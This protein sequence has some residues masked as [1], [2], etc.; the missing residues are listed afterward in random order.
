M[1]SVFEDALK[2][3]TSGVSDATLLAQPASIPMTP[4]LLC[5]QLE[6]ARMAI[7]VYPL[8]RNAMMDNTIILPLDSVIT[9]GSHAPIARDLPQLALL[10]TNPTSCLEQPVSLADHAHLDLTQLLKDARP[11]LKNVEPAL[12]LMCAQPAPVDLS[13]MVLTA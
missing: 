3:H 12:T 10:V 1:D 8:F 6:P 5:A 11:A 13:I 9:V 4:V 2:A 7:N